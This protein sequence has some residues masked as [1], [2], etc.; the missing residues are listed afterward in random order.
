LSHK[1]VEH[2]GRTII[3]GDDDDPAANSATYRTR[4][5]A[6]QQRH[7][8]SIA[9]AEISVTDSLCRD[10][11]DR[12]CRRGDDDVMMKEFSANRQGE[13]VRREGLRLPTSKARGSYSR[14][15]PRG[16]NS[17]QR[18]SSASSRSKGNRALQVRMLDPVP[19]VARRSQAVER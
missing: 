6:R 9:R 11:P 18:V 15:P 16:R 2:R 3:A 7:V 12:S 14:C 4:P 8:F 17:G 19:S 5:V 1:G 10:H 13:V